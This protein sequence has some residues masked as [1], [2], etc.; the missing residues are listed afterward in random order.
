[1]AGRVAIRPMGVADVTAAAAAVLEGGW[2]DRLPFFAWAVDHPACRPFVAVEGERI[3]GTGIATA[4]GPVGWVGTIFVVPDRR[5][6]GLGRRLTQAVIDDLDGRGCR[7]LVLIATVLGRPIYERLGF[8][9]LAD[10]LRFSIRGSGDATPLDRVR[11]MAADDLPAILAL[12]RAAT[13]EDRAPVLTGLVGPESTRVVVHADGSIGGF[14]AR[15]PWGGG[16]LVAPDP[17]DALELL[18]WRRRR[19]GPEA[20]V[21]TGLPDSNAVGRARLLSGGWSESAAA[22][23]M[24]RGEPLDWRPDWIWGQ[25]NGALG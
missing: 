22:V 23:R 12:D 15:G 19:A 3:V 11:P 24:F 18:E 16:A 7:T 9:R 4:Y 1:M 21:A 6:S 2:G 8:E 10:H 5:G 25:F 20:L 17:D 13:G 14:V